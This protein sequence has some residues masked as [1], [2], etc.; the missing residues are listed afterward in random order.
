MVLANCPWKTA[1]TNGR[2]CGCDESKHHI[3]ISCQWGLFWN[4]TC[5]VLSLDLSWNKQD[6]ERCERRTDIHHCSVVKISSTDLFHKHKE[7]FRSLTSF[8]GERG[9][10][11]KERETMVKCRDGGTLAYGFSFQQLFLCFPLTKSI[12][13]RLN[14][15]R[16]FFSFFFFSRGH[17]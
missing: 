4:T 2:T 7:S 3:I 1:S 17:F 11:R 16:F 5:P 8:N 15:P 14:P 10:E 6:N 9:R 13:A 12:W